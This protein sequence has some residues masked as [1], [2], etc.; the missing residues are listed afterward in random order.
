[1]ELLWS[2]CGAAVELL[3]SCYGTA[4]A[5]EAALQVVEGTI[6]KALHRHGSSAVLSIEHSDF[7]D[8]NK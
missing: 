5:R 4:T 7:L 3:W 8:W 1:M 2:C 6:V